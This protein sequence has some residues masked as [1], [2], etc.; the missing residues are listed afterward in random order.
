MRRIESSD[1]NDKFFGFDG[2]TVSI[3]D[4][5][6]GDEHSGNHQQAECRGRCMLDCDWDGF[7]TIPSIGLTKMVESDRNRQKNRN[8]DC[9][10]APAP[11]ASAF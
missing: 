4:T 1:P 5:E 6:R 8:R 3:G 7:D 2:G 11:I 9:S 10:E